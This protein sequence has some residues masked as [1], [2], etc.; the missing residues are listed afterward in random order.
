MT[1]LGPDAAA[2]SPS[3]S[4]SSSALIDSIP[5]YLGFTEPYFQALGKE[6]RVLTT[7]FQERWIQLALG[8]GPSSR[9]FAVALGYVV[10]S[11]I[12]ALYLNLLTVGNA[13]TAGL[14]VRNAVR[15][16]LL[17]LKVRHLLKLR[18]LSC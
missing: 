8:G 12:L 4:T 2:I 11:F 1:T 15:Q 7:K 10:I 18:L 9:V 3:N 6:V 16:Q 14:A 5:E 17:V 13:R